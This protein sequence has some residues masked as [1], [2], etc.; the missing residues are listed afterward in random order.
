R[1]IGAFHNC[2]CESNHQIYVFQNSGSGSFTNY[3]FNRTTKVDVNQIGLYC[4]YDFSRKRHCLFVSTKNLDSDRTFIVKNIEFLTTFYSISDKP[5]RRNKFRVHQICSVQFAE[6]T[7]RRI[8]YVFH[9]SQQKRML[10]QNNISYFGHFGKF[11]QRYVFSIR[12][13]FY[14]SNYNILLRFRKIYFP[15]EV[16]TNK[17][18]LLSWCS[19]SVHSTPSSQ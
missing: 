8:A 12:V 2:F 1:K 3:F 18:L 10:G 14:H 5:F 6:S 19:S 9:R 17:D 4:L 13:P 15:T 11:L 16:I 7:K